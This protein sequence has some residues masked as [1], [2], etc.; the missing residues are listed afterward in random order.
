MVDAG[1]QIPLDALECGL[2][3][4]RPWQSIIFRM[5]ESLA[6][7]QLG[8]LES[9]GSNP[10]ILTGSVAMHGSEAQ[11]VEQPVVNR[12]GAGASPVRAAGDGTSAE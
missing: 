9:A 11:T 3:D 8:V 2:R 6:I 4:E 12:K 5:W 7:R 1:V 10:A